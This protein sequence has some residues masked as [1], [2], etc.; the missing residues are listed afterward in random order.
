MMNDRDIKI[1]DLSLS[2]SKTTILQKLCG[3]N[4]YM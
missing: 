3:N 1:F 4:L 2:A